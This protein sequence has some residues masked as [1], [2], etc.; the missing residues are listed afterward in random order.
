[1]YAQAPHGS[2]P[3]SAVLQVAGSLAPLAAASRDILLAMLGTVVLGSL[4]V[5]I[6]SYWLAASAVHPVL[7]IADQAGHI[8]PEAPSRITTHADVAE[9]ASLIEVLNGLL[10]RSERAF[11]AQ[12]RLIGDVGHEL[13][14]PLTALQG[15]IEIALRSVRTPESY[16]HTLRSGLEEIERMT[17]MCEELLLIT[18]A[19]A[20]T[21]SLHRV[22]VD[23][24]ELLRDCA[25]AM[26]RRL[27]EKHVAVTTRFGYAGNP[28]F[29][30]A[31]LIGR[32]IEELMD[33]A[34]KFT[35]A[36]GAI[37]LGTDPTETAARLW[38]EDSGPGLPTEQF[39][40]LFEPFYRADAA[41]TRD[42]GTGLGLSMAASVTRAHGGTI[43]ARNL[44]QR[45]ARF[46]VE[47]PVAGGNGN[48]R[49][50][51]AVTSSLGK[52]LISG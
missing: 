2:P 7:E 16:Q 12:R 37:V 49:G 48:G 34:V 4:A 3:G 44:P 15:E 40:H 41:R 39:S 47:L 27:D 35:P 19:E 50:A 32:V 30:D 5:A 23:P 22:E 42:E 36:G 45:G 17:A 11:S 18:R 51:Y 29:V 21:L 43:R 20:R 6:G 33:N 28:L 38:V 10:E 26:R 8:M 52:T 1:V 9:Y 31:E 25:D 14:T 13:K 46:E 24:N